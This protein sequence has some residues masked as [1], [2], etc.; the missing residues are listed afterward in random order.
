MSL[1]VFSKGMKDKEGRLNFVLLFQ[2][3][4][5]A[6]MIKVVNIQKLA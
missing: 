1:A 3:I 6:D 5:K 2:A 4:K